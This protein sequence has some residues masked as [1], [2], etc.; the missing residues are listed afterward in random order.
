[1]E[2]LTYSK[3]MDLEKICKKIFEFVIP[4][5]EKNE[6]PISYINIELGF[7]VDI[8]EN[9][10]WETFNKMRWDTKLSSAELLLIK[11]SYTGTDKD[12]SIRIISL[13]VFEDDGKSSPLIPI[14]DGTII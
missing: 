6:S 14:R 10:L 9:N 11:K 1:M 5:A 3:N 2:K 13:S 4:Y 12:S 7:S 8:S